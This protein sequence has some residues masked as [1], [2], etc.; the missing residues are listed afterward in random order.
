MPQS[1]NIYSWYDEKHE[2]FA[3]LIDLFSSV[4]SKIIQENGKWILVGP[5][6]R[7][8]SQENGIYVRQWNENPMLLTYEDQPIVKCDK[9]PLQVFMD[10]LG[11]YPGE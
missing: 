1:Y 6:I 7:S 4:G 9:T 5:K 11:Y 10:E 8:M 2:E 3:Q